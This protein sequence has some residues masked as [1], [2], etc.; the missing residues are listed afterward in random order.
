VAKLRS[1]WSDTGYVSQSIQ[2]VDDAD[3]ECEYIFCVCSS[4]LGAFTRLG[5]W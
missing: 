3:A 5:C 4:E 1:M 2:L